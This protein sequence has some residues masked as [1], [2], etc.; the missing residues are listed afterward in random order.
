[1]DLAEFESE[2]MRILIAH[3]GPDD[4]SCALR[5]GEPATFPTTADPAA[6]LAQIFERSGVAPAES[7]LYL[8]EEES[9]SLPHR[10]RTTQL[11]FEPPPPDGQGVLAEP[12]LGYYHD[13]P[14]AC[15]LYAS[16]LNEGI[17]LDITRERVRG[18]MQC[19]RRAVGTPWRFELE[20]SSQ[21]RTHVKLALHFLRS[22]ASSQ[23]LVDGSDLLQPAALRQLAR[24]AMYLWVRSFRSLARD[25]AAT[26]AAVRLGRELSCLHQ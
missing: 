10:E 21:V 25:G 20:G 2:G 14:A 15:T 12:A 19:S 4:T 26:R 18:A 23:P 16:G 11:I 8:I 13:D 7:V 6:R 1:M 22:A 24:L 9:S 5:G 3:I 17:V